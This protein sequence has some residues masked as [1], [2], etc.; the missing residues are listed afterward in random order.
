M[1]TIASQ[2]EPLLRDWAHEVARG[3]AEHVFDVSQ[4]EC[5]EASGETRESGQLQPRGETAWTITYDDR[6]F[7]DEGPEAH[8]IEG[9]PLLVFDWEKLGLYP[10]V[11][12]HVQWEPGEGV[13]RNR[14]WFSERSATD[15]VYYEGLLDAAEATPF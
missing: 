3:G 12:R 15:D 9:N 10:A 14:G 1:A 6:G 4:D 13:E 2:L 8:P 5:P 7:T 11:F